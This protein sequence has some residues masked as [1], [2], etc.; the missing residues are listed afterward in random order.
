[1]R[2]Y[3]VS[4]IGGRVFSVIEGTLLALFCG[5]MYLTMMLVVLFLGSIAI[6]TMPV[7]GWFAL[8][9]AEKLI[10]ELKSEISTLKNEALAPE[11]MVNRVV[12]EP[13]SG[14]NKAMDEPK[15]TEPLDMDLCVRGYMDGFKGLPSQSD[16][17]SYTQGWENGM[18][19]SGR[20]K[21]SQE[22]ADRARNYL[23]LTTV[24]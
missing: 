21:M 6:I 1:M 10:E 24:K 15:T 13:K 2:I 22:Q 7:W 14:V 4:D 8:Y 18:V 16:D 11:S 20:Q 23:K 12:D 5:I 19:D 17:S 9:K 3:G